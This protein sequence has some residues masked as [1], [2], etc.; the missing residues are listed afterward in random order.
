MMTRCIKR[1]HLLLL[2][3]AALHIAALA[4][5]YYEPSA[6]SLASP[7]VISWTAN[8]A[9]R[10]YVFR[11]NA[12]AQFFISTVQYPTIQNWATG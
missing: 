11:P 6:S 9:N 2:S 8:G 5:C 3:A 10:R 4:P 12:G 7:T 1:K